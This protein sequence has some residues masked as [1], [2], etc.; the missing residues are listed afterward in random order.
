MHLTLHSVNRRGERGEHPQTGSDI[1]MERLLLSEKET[2][3][4]LGIGRTKLHELKKAGDL[5]QVH[6]GR[7]SFI[8]AQSVHAY[9]DALTQAATPAI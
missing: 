2:L 8:T 3:T 4:A 1:E 7:R 6:I 5:I 9:V